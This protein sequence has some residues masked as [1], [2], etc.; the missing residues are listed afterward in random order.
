MIHLKRWQVGEMIR[1]ALAE[2]PNEACG[3]LAG[4]EGRVEKV[5]S[6]T[7]VEHSPSAYRL[8]PEEQGRAFMEIKENGWEL[9]ALY[10]SH[11][12]LPAYPS[13]RDVEM[14]FYSDSIYV[15]ISL[16]EVD[17]PNLRAFRIVDGVVNEEKLLI[18]D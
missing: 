5:Y 13:A 6:L 1:H 2:Y 9:L 11:T 7:N 15:I 18:E 10:H 3:L 8:D 17:Q 12:H 16:T 14:A 4:K